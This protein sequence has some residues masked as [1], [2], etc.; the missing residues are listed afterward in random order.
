VQD[1]TDFP[2][3]ALATLRFAQ[4]PA[5]FANRR[6]VYSFRDALMG[7]TE[8]VQGL[9]GQGSTFVDGV[10]VPTLVARTGAASPGQRPARSRG[11]RRRFLPP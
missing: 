11:G 7:R 2:T 3:T 6:H 4:P 1:A 5:D 9:A 10:F 8:R